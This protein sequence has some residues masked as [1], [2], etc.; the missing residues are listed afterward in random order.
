MA[1]GHSALLSSRTANS[2][3]SVCQHTWSAR[4][5]TLIVFLVS[6]F[7]VLLRSIA[8]DAASKTASKVQPSEEA[9]NRLDEP[10]EE[11]TWHDTPD[12]SRDNLKNQLKTKTPF[13]KGDAKKVA[14]DASEAAHPSGERDPQAT[15][16]LA[17]REQQ[18]EPGQSS[19]TDPVAGAQ[20]GL[21]TVKAK[22][23]EAFPDD[24]KEQGKQYKARTNNYLKEKVMPKER[25]EQ[26][27]WRLKK[28]VVEVQGHQDCMHFQDLAFTR[29]R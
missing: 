9:L 10:A 28:M 12:L 3:S 26:T 21:D 24:K 7:T 2:E 14:G 15:A 4:A 25:R 27:I 18:E 6:D 16:D 22:A 17:A 23:S 13:N 5:H 19:S 1:Y 29:I 20:A 8:G 11:N